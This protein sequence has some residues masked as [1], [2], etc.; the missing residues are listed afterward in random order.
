M[1]P[2]PTLLRPTLV[3]AMSALALLACSNAER[4]QR[5]RLEE[6]PAATQEPVTA[7][8][9]SRSA[10]AGAD[11]SVD[12]PIDAQVDVTASS[13]ARD[14]AAL[15]LSV[16]KE[17]KASMA[18]SALA[19]RP[20]P[21]AEAM[22]ALQ[23]PRGREQYRR[24]AD[25]PVRHVLSEPV[26]TFSIDVDGASFSLVRS[27]LDQGRLPPVDAVRSEEIIN[28]LDLRYELGLSR[29]QPVGLSTRLMAT[30]W[31]TDTRLL[32]VGV[33]G[34]A[35]ARE[36]LPPSNYVFL[37]DVSGSMRGDDRLGL[38]RRAFTV[39]LEQL[40][41]GDTV[42]LVTYASGA[43]TVLEPTP[44]S[45]RH[46][47]ASALQ[48]LSAGG[49]THGSDGIQRA[50]AMA[51]QGFIK[52]GNNRVILATDGDL[53]VGLTGQ[54]LVDMIERQRDRGI[55]L[56]VLGVGQGNYMDAQLEPLAHHGDG[57]YYYLDSFNEARRVLV[58]G[59]S[60]TAFAVAK[61]VKIQ[62]EFNPAVVAE[63]RLIGYN[64]RQLA[65]ADFNN[66]A[67][68][69]GELGAGQSVTALY[70]ITLREGAY[71]FVDERRYG[72]E[73][74]PGGRRDELAWVK[75]RYKPEAGAASRR[76][77]TV[78][79]A[80]RARGAEP[81]SAAVVAAAFAE[82]LRGSSWLADYHWAALQQLQAQAAGTARSR[83]LA[84]MIA[85]AA[86]LA[87]DKTAGH[88]TERAS[89]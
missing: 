52:G 68:D 53:N 23:Q 81:A 41:D 89:P 87:G 85:T 56:T 60:G 62:V 46:K 29:R 73:S 27:Y 58:D 82:K 4:E 3:M 44:V 10:E 19:G 14:P 84:E 37:I 8:R 11:T 9:E 7:Q 61:D 31:N 67:K 54:A 12:G 36:A 42:A 78:V 79:A 65:E 38:I 88:T 21:V 13:P 47:I 70:E 77:D 83:E 63:Y 72:A 18:D 69:A 30:P 16:A 22:V 6:R 74:R 64:N 66:D 20:V 1:K 59:L 34:W 55:Y 28:A 86:L 57:N 26:S 35:P 76:I 71:R 45:E 33:Q 5:A 2:L 75:L 25:N 80:D 32:Q 40:R 39:M 15:Q 50:Y 17:R 51:E 24:W 49:S 48:A 43:N